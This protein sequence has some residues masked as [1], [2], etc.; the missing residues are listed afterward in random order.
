MKLSKDFTLQELSKSEI[1]DRNNINNIPK[2]TVRKII[3]RL[4]RSIK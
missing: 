1:A 4:R 3:K 2:T